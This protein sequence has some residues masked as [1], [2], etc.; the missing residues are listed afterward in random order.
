[1]NKLKKRLH[2]PDH[3]EL[4]QSDINHLRRLLA[5]LRCENA[6]L[7]LDDEAHKKINHGLAGKSTILALAHSER[8]EKAFSRWPEYVHSAVR[9]LDKTITQIDGDVTDVPAR[10]VFEIEDKTDMIKRGGR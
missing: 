7:Y 2:K 10:R 6:Y 3:C 5:W 9:A 1:M 8:I 4:S